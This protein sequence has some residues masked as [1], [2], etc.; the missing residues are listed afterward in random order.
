M[1]S[2][3]A[4]RVPGKGGPPGADGEAHSAPGRQT[5]VEAAYPSLAAPLAQAMRARGANGD[6]VPTASDAATAAVEG[7]GAG[8]PLDPGMAARVGG[9]LG[10]DFSGVRVH[11]DPLA[12]QASAALGAR[13]FAFHRDVFLAKG[14]SATDVR[15]MAHELTH[16]AQQGGGRPV[17]QAKVAVGDANGPAEHEA[18]AVA[19]AVADGAPPTALLVDGGS[20]APGQMPKAEFL[21]QL[22]AAVTAAASAELGDLA[23]GGA[24]AADCPYIA[25]YFARYADQ[26]AAACEALIKRY[27]PAARTVQT[28]AELVP[29]VVAQ[30]R[31]G[32]RAWRDTGRPPPEL[33]AAE[34]EAAAAATTA[35]ATPAAQT[36]RTPDGRDTLASLEAELGP[37]QPL[38]GGV[39][40]RMVDGLGLDVSGVRLHTGPVAARKAADVDALAFAV[41]P[42]IVMS[43]AAP[44]AGTLDGDALLAHEIVHTAQQAD[45]ARDPVARR[46][47]IGEESA[48][49]E[50]H[51]DASAASA[52]AALHGGAKQPGLLQRLGAAM[53]TGLRLQR[54]SGKKPAPVPADPFLAKLHARLHATPRDLAGFYSDITA[55]AKAHAGNAGTRAGYETFVSDGVLSY[56]EAMRAV[57]A[58][59][60]GAERDWPVPVKNFTA[61]VESGT[62]PVSALA[63]SGAGPLL[64]FCVKS[65]SAAGDAPG[66][67]IAA[68]RTAFNARWNVAPYSAESTEFD[69]A[70]TSKGPRNPRA[71]KIFQ[72]LYADPATKLAYDTNT[73]PG[74][75]AMCDTLNSPDGANLIASP[76]LQELRAALTGGRIA[77][78][79][80]G[81]ADPAYVTLVTAVR[82]KATALDAADRSE[83]DLQH[84]WRLIVDDAVRGTTPAITAAVRADLWSVVSSSFPPAPA[85]PPALPAP[86]EPAPAV[87]AAQKTFLDHITITAPSPQ[88]AESDR[89]PVTFS[90]KSTVPNPGLA[91][92]RHIVVGPAANVPEGSDDETAWPAGVD[93]LDHTAKINP[94]NPVPGTPLKVTARLTMPPVAPADFAEK[95]HDVEVNDKRV[96]WVTT[97]FEPGVIAVREMDKIHVAAGNK[98]KFFGGQLPLRLSGRFK[99]GGTNPGLALSVEGEVKQA[100]AVVKTLTRQ[101]FPEHAAQTNLPDV[102]LV[103]PTPPPA[104]PQAIEVA[105]RVFQGTGA[106]VL[107]YTPPPLAF[108]AEAGAPPVVGGDAGILAADNAMLNQPIGTAGSFLHEM[109]ATAPSP[110]SAQARVADAVATGALKVQACMRRSDS[111]AW[112]TAQGKAVDQNIAWAMG[113]I[114]DAHT[115]IDPRSGQAG[116]HWPKFNDTVFLN[117][118]LD[119]HTGTKRPRAD[120]FG[121]LAHEGIH[122]ADRPAG[123]G[124]RFGAYEEEFRAYWIEGTGAGKSTGYD[125]S[126]P[127]PGPKSPRAREIFNHLY[128][129]PTYKFVRLDYDANTDGFRD[130]CDRYFMP[131]GVNLTL[132]GELTA[133]RQEIEAYAGVDF[134]AKKAAVTAKLAACAAGD[135]HEVEANRAWRDLVEQKFPVAGERTQIKTVLGIPQ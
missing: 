134:P 126:L 11:S 115:M 6:A 61:G 88:D 98:F 117:V 4:P 37:G 105:L 66:D 57:A 103:E 124:D 26:P 90:I 72:S 118:T 19:K 12:Q 129:N 20:L 70:L 133:L 78:P 64:E 58:T 40:S 42:N 102:I 135:K 18:D 104:A 116:W 82:P 3:K 49:A 17:A 39:A 27:A 45:A 52:V 44:A 9:H 112:L 79:V 119:T 5:L 34:P 30:V 92:R 113:Q 76:R 101:V 48:A 55:D 71:Y 123:A 69:P 94:E 47:A 23:G 93:K 24:G 8:A 91:A 125:A 59:E 25:D 38:P 128:Y 120:L 75:R 62:F 127:Y 114:D 85:V 77:A 56:K 96:H 16:V 29:A 14:E 83:V 7:K 132:S 33:V 46:K 21:A 99:A 65:G 53:K 15:L 95:K 84:Q 51:A 131:D 28:A 60:L 73:P 81:T 87:N 130:K 68:Y 41:G 1:G 106:G 122:A 22:R 63:P 97:H 111:A 13:A 100:G 107:I 32:V 109:K 36:L 80:A 2:G 31:G 50:D 108:Q 10:T 54:C 121:L 43:A 86:A 35:P 110:T 89:H 67:P 74:F